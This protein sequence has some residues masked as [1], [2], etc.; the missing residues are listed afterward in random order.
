MGWVEEQ[1]EGDGQ[2]DGGKQDKGMPATPAGAKF[3]RQ[4]AGDGVR[5]GIEDQ[6]NRERDTGA[7]R[8]DMQYLIIVKQ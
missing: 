2:G 5:K 1:K 7:C 8:R 3:I 6:G 4:A